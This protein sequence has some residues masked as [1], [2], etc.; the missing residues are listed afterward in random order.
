MISSKRILRKSQLCFN[1]APS[2][3]GV[4]TEG[5][6]KMRKK[7][8]KTMVSLSKMEARTQSRAFSVEKRKKLLL[9]EE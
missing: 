3:R 2:E 8:S 9:N 4:G 7:I 1:F 5:E 6:K